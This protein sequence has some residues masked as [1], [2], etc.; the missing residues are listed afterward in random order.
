MTV[1]EKL[2]KMAYSIEAR[3]QTVEADKAWEVS[4]TR[5]A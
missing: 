3:N 1:I 2:E 5:G 4:I